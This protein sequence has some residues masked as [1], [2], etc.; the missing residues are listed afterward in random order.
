MIR[1]LTFY[2]EENVY[3]NNQYYVEPTL[4]NCSKHNNIPF[5]KEYLHQYY[6]Y[7]YDDKKIDRGYYY[8]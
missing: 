5:Q 6:V 2:M 3:K 4:I 1:I 7:V 8:V